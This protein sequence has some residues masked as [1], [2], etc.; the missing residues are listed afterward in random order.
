VRTGTANVVL[1]RLQ[2]SSLRSAQVFEPFRRRP[3]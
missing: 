1:R 2:S 3:R